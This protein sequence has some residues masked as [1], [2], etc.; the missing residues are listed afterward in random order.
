MNRSGPRSPS[1]RSAARRI[2]CAEAVRGASS[3]SGKRVGLSQPARAVRANR[4]RGR[5]PRPET[6]I[7]PAR[8]WRDRL[9]EYWQSAQTRLVCDQA[10][11]L[12]NEHAVGRIGISP[13]GQAA[14]GVIDPSA[15]HRCSASH[16]HHGT[17]RPLAPTDIIKNR[18]ALFISHPGPSLVSSKRQSSRADR[19][20]SPPTSLWEPLRG[21]AD[22]SGHSTLARPILRIEDRD[23]KCDMIMLNMIGVDPRAD[24]CQNSRPEAADG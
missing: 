5:P 11:F 10:H 4:V 23:V 2:S 21:A 12:E 24:L 15:Q 1:W 14:R 17:F 20:H 19:G 9:R 13:A 6:R 3:G 18:L 7:T 16:L 8:D 22:G